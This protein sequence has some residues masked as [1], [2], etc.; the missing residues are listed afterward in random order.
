MQNMQRTFKMA[1]FGAGISRPT[2]LKQKKHQTPSRSSTAQNSSHLPG[3]RRRRD[4]GSVGNHHLVDIHGSG[5]ET[6]PDAH[7]AWIKP[8]TGLCPHA[9]LCPSAPHHLPLLLSR[10]ASSP[11]LSIFFRSPPVGCYLSLL[12]WHIFPRCHSSR[13]SV[14]SSRM[15]V[16]SS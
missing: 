5:E 2:W 10:E 16:M 4:R 1:T 9:I 7:V 13:F 6:L 15:H 12:K 3:P 8:T 14:F 11:E